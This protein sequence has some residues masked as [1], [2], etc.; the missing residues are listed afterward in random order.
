MKNGLILVIDDD[1]GILDVISTV[2]MEGKHKVVPALKLPSTS[3][4]SL[5]PDLVIIDIS[6]DDSRKEH[7]YKN[8]K[9]D[10]QTSKIPVLLTSTSSRLDKTAEKWNAEAFILK[11]FDIDDLAAKVNELLT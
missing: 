10:P 7:F 8:L 4:A 11:P 9:A 1:E 2:L 6:L 5:N 3:V